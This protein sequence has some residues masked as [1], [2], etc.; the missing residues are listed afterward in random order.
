MYSCT[1]SL[2]LYGLEFIECYIDKETSGKVKEIT[3]RQYLLN[4]EMNW[5]NKNVR[6]QDKPTGK[7]C[8]CLLP[9]C[10]NLL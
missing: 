2:K 8:R 3:D 1:L 4:L 7:C 9:V 6:N 10:H 5:E